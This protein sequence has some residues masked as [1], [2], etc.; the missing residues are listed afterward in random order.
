VRLRT[1]RSLARV[2]SR[3][4]LKTDVPRGSE[5]NRSAYLLPVARHSASQRN[6]RKSMKHW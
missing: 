3:G 1:S 2:E 5:P 6:A 4:Y